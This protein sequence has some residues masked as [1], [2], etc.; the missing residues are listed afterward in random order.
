LARFTADP[1]AFDLVITDMTMPKM[2]GDRLARKIL[3]IR[4]DMPIILCTG[5]SER[6]TEEQARQIGIKGFAYKPIPIND[7]AKL[8]RK[9]L[10][11]ESF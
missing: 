11:E 10:E 3:E 5:Y 1:D 7:L 4:P 2:T 8:I 9:V 6:L